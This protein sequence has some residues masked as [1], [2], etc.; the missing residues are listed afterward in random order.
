LEQLV[1]DLPAVASR[2]HHPAALAMLRRAGEALARAVAEGCEDEPALIARVRRD[3]SR[4]CLAALAPAEVCRLQ[5]QVEA[6]LARSTAG[7]SQ[8]ARRRR[9]E[10]LWER[11]LTRHC[12][13]VYPSEAGW[14]ANAEAGSSPAR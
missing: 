8:R 12:G 14:L 13:L 4:G 2:L 3:M 5:V 11:A 6:D 10:T 1:E 9:E 7:A